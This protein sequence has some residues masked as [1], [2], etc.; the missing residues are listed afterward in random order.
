MIKKRGATRSNVLQG[1]D[2]ASLTLWKVDV[3]YNEE[4]RKKIEGGQ[5]WPAPNDSVLD[6]MKLISDVW[7]RPPDGHLHVFVR[8]PRGVSPSA[9]SKAASWYEAAKNLY[10]VMWGNNLEERLLNVAGC[11]GLKYFPPTEVKNLQL[12]ALGC[13]VNAI[14]F[15]E[16]YPFTLKRLQDRRPNLGGLNGLQ[17][18]RLMI[19][20][21]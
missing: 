15:R 12:R 17:I 7:E 11:E 13:D 2:A 20:A 14:L 3:N 10:R 5:Y 16:E 8:P 1:V 9:S 19:M 4:T 18:R 21:V 6:A